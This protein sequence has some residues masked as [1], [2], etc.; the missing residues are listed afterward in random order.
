MGNFIK[1]EFD[2]FLVLEQI[3]IF[4]ID[5]LFLDLLSWAACRD[6]EGDDKD[7][8]GENDAV[9]DNTRAEHE[10]VENPSNPEVVF[11]KCALARTESAS[12]HS[13]YLHCPWTDFAKI[14]NPA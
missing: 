13:Q 6:E 11:G 10:V 14:L 9:G 8:G 3:F 4:D 5:F 7:D 12:V 1:S 2:T